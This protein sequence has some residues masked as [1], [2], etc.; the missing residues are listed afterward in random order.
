MSAGKY[1]P[2]W[3][4]E[5]VAA[6]ARLYKT[7]K[8]FREH[9]DGAYDAARRRLNIL[10]DVCAHMESSRGK[11]RFWSRERVQKLVQKCKTYEGFRS[12]Y[13]E[14]YKA[15]CRYGWPDLIADLPRT[16]TPPDW[17][18][19]ERV[20]EEAKKYCT[21][22]EFSKGSPYAYRAAHRKQWL[23]IVC[24]HMERMQKPNGYWTRETVIE[25]AKRYSSRSEFQKSAGGAY[26]VAA[27]HDFLDE[28]CAHMEKRGSQYERAVYA[29]E[30]DD[31]SVYVGLT[32]DYD[33]R[34]REHLTQDKHIG[35][36]LKTTPAKYVRFNQWFSLDEAAKEEARR[37][38]E[39][40]KSGWKILNR[41]KPGGV[42]SRPRKWTF[43]EI[44]TLA[45][46]YETVSAFIAGHTTA[47]Q[48]ACKKGWWPQIS[49]HLTRAVE[50]GKWTVEALSLEARK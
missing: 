36:K 45:G 19:L 25:E 42:G 18:T 7:R 20:G 6:E 35:R 23:D 30:F 26:S 27:K 28:A 24:A 10:D 8:E 47:Y 38:D 16:R 49:A 34:Y 40:D 3:T 37:I 15:V 1:G 48:T 11:E 13:P 31:H 46:Q 29:F 14:A 4:P 41:A 21:R 22:S 50:H 32:F 43:D 33:V 39:Y 5:A 44:K 9:A 2:P 12:D 17:W